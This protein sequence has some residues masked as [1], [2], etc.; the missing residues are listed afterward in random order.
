M[1]KITIFFSLL[2][3]F[4][5]SLREPNQNFYVHIRNWTKNIIQTFKCYR[6]N[7]FFVRSIF[8]Q[9]GPKYDI[10]GNFLIDIYIELLL[11]LLICFFLSEYELFRFFLHIHNVSLFLFSSCKWQ[12]IEYSL[13]L[14]DSASTYG[15]MVQ[16]QLMFILVLV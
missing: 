5:I 1:V 10:S 14:N 4:I 16:I 7:Y 6:Y 11:H 13:F 15:W 8:K 9:H 3:L 12:S 2:C